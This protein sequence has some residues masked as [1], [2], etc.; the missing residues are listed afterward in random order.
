[1]IRAY[2][3]LSKNRPYLHL[4]NVTSTFIFFTFCCY[5]LLVNEKVT[6]GVGLF[7]VAIMVALFSQ[8]SSY[9]QKYLSKD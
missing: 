4:F 6:F 2:A 8:A 1:M 3:Y 9:R 5:Q 7:F